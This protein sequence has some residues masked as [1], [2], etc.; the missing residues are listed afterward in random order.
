M[1]VTVTS[2]FSAR[3]PR[4]SVASFVH[5]PASASRHWYRNEVTG[6]VACKVP[7]GVV[8]PRG[9]SL[10][11]FHLRVIRS[12]RPGTGVAT[13]CCCRRLWS[14][15]KT[16]RPLTWITVHGPSRSSFSARTR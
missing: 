6:P 14:S 13:G 5:E 16:G 12:P 10:G 15:R 9:V 3:L 4:A 8:E 2:S 11:T 7:W 1:T